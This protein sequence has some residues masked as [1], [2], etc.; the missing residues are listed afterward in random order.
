MAGFESGYLVVDPFEPTPPGTDVLLAPVTLGPYLVGVAF[1]AGRTEE[2]PEYGVFPTFF[3]LKDSSLLAVT[4][5]CLDPDVS[6]ADKVTERL[7]G[8]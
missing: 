1:A 5:C 3:P 4:G 8:A 6:L 7:F 2:P